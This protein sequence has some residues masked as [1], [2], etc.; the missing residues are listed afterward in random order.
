MRESTAPKNINRDEV[1]KEIREQ[2]LAS[3]NQEAPISSSA[4]ARQFGVKAPTMDY[5]IKKLIEEKRIIQS[6]RKRKHNRR[7]YLLPESGNEK[8]VYTEDD[9]LDPLK[10]I[11]KDKLGKKT[12]VETFNSGFISLP[13]ENQESQE[14]LD[15]LTVNKVKP[16]KDNI[17]QEQL[18]NVSKNDK[19]ENFDKLNLDSKI[20]EFLKS[21]NDL[22]TAE[23]LLTHADKEILSVMNESIQQNILYL[24]DLSEELST[25]QSK[26]LIS[27]LIDERN[28]YIEEKNKLQEEN[29]QLKAML[30]E[31]QGKF[32]LD[33]QRIR[34]I[35]QNIMSVIDSFLDQPNHS[36][37]LNRKE[38]RTT[39][40][41][42]ISDA[43]RYILNLDK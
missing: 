5:H 24:K 2:I 12:D 11:I 10:K 21:S 33:P 30:K 15:I 41:K 25:M 27:E 28:N 7:V 42:Q 36:L 22:P 29:D 34:H 8:V 9:D 1:Y 38:F 40:T 14:N 3:P 35:Q 16:I 39:I 43:F 32:D 18:W 17:K 19:I 13:Q 31:N 20:E 4:L 23:Q 37:A 6:E 26:Q